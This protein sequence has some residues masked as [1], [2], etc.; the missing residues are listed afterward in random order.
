MADAGVPG[1]AKT[2]WGRVF[3][4]LIVGGVPTAI[5]FI[6][7]WWWWGTLFLLL[8]L[9]AACLSFS[10]VARPTVF[11]LVAAFAIGWLAGAWI[12]VAVHRAGDGDA[13]WR[14]ALPIVGGIVIGLVSTALFWFVTLAVSTKWVLGLDQSHEEIGWWTAFWFVAL[15]AFG[16]AQPYVSV[17]NGKMNDPSKQGL[18]AQY[19]KPDLVSKFGGPGMLVVGEGN[20]VVLE[21][22]GQLS[23][24]LGQGTHV[25]KHGEW[26][27][28]PIED[29]GIHSL[30]GAGGDPQTVK[31]VLTKDGYPLDITIG[32]KGRLELKA[33]TDKRPESQVEGGEANS[34]VINPDTPL[35][36]Y[37]DT[38]RK[39]AG[40]WRKKYPGGAV[41]KLRDVVATY[42]LDQILGDPGAKQK[43]ESDKRV[44][45]QIEDKVKELVGTNPS[46]GV[47]FNGINIRDIK[48]AEDAPKD[49]REAMLERW[50]S[51]IQRE[52]MLREA[53]TK[54]MTLEKESEGRAE[55]I[56]RIEEAR[57]HQSDQWLSIIEK[58]KEVLPEVQNPR[59]AYGFVSVIRDLLSRVGRDEKD[60][61]QQIFR[62]QRLLS[63][64][65]DRDDEEVS[66]I[67]SMMPTMI[68]GQTTTVEEGKTQ[69]PES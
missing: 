56:R 3:V 68:P 25:L 24:I 59:V 38:V 14:G 48:I 5:C 1:Q 16:Y 12:D 67:L 61:L 4:T 32:G 69:E 49:V 51:L 45:K 53:E 27:R 44:T 63:G 23:R 50:A 66:S 42:T 43:E 10:T 33:D 40:G 26:F 29:K 7:G 31:N 2:N 28:E 21:R 58:L 19:M 22:G 46:G 54:R 57:M 11:T 20:V 65:S 9:F 37:E 34:R 17:S 15:R 47:V 39:A 41:D 8:T 52:V 36:I 55:F 35:A 30:F 64:H 18:F 62:L 60:D 6:L 13:W